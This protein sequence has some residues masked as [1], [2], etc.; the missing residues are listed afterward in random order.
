MKNL[1]LLLFSIFFIP[2]HLIAQCNTAIPTNAVVIDS[3]Q[4]INGGFDP[5]WV[6]SGD[7]IKTDGGFHNIYLESGAVMTSGGGIDTIF[8]KNN[9]TFFMNGGIHYIY[10]EN[11]NDLH[12]AGGIP[13]LDS[14]PSINFNYINAPAN[15]C[16]P[17]PVAS[18]QSSDSSLCQ[19]DCIN[20]MDMGINATSWQWFFPGAT[21]S[22]DTLKNPQN[23]CYTTAG[24]FDV[25]LVVNNS[26]GSDTLLLANLITVNPL[27]AVSAIQNANVLSVTSG[28]LAY[29][30]Y[31]GNILLPGDTTFI[32]SVFQNGNYK[33]MVTDSNGCDTTITFIYAG[34]GLNENPA[35]VTQFLIL[36]NPANDYIEIVTQKSLAPLK[37]ENIKIEIAD[38]MGKIIL[39]NKI[40]LKLKTPIPLNN[41]ASGIYMV[42]IFTLEGLQVLKLVVE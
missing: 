31:F 14:C 29:Q 23:I 40:N 28:F 26:S 13:T 10:Y 18:F 1:L 17:G 22:T 32:L 8:V 5:M 41:F 3:T 12:I 21:P 15:G 33:V 35:N 25:T 42:K 30:W 11:N 38:G 9:A 2:T 16:F 39:Q 37:Y 4:T 6:C 34:A 7:T 20:F 24:S 36:P 27:P 19:G